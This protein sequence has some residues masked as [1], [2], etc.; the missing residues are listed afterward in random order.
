MCVFKAFLSN[1]I[2]IIT[3]TNSSLLVF[4]FRRGADFDLVVFVF[5]FGRRAGPLL[6]VLLQ[7]GRGQPPRQP[8]PALGGGH[9]GLQLE[10]HLFGIVKREVNRVL[11]WE[12]DNKLNQN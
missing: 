9:L 10:A 4:F 1:D 8:Y 3:I 2:H 7:R 6:L 11:I 5:V 12:S